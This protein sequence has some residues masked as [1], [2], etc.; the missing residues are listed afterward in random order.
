MG[1]RVRPA[2]R[3][4]ASVLTMRGGGD[5]TGMGRVWT[6][7]WTIGHRLLHASVWETL[8]QSARA[9]TH[10]HTHTHTP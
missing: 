6:W 9:R 3:R 1:I 10:T 5:G 7:T 2:T 4:Y 8:P